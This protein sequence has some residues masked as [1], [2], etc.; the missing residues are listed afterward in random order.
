MEVW[1]VSGERQ[2]APG[3]LSEPIKA[4]GRAL[5]GEVTTGRRAG[6]QILLQSDFPAAIRGGRRVPQ[7]VLELESAGERDGASES[8][9]L[10]ERKQLRAGDP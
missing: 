6:T 3:A 2:R 7:S 8:A 10:V 5:A 9:E 4:R 1:S